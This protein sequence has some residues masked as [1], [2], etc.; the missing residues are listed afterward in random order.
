[1]NKLPQ[2][3]SC[4]A[5][6]GMVSCTAR[7]C[8]HCGHPIRT[9]RKMDAIRHFRSLLIQMTSAITHK[10]QP[11]L[12]ICLRVSFFLLVM[13]GFVCIN[14]ILRIGDLMNAS[15]VFELFLFSAL[16]PATIHFPA[17]YFSRRIINPK[18]SFYIGRFSVFLIGLSMVASSSV[19]ER[20]FL[21]Q[22]YRYNAIRNNGLSMTSAYAICLLI[23]V[24]WT[25]VLWRETTKSEVMMNIKH[26]T[27]DTQT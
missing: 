15:S 19:I 3:F 21:Y 11:I 6:H 24:C 4:P 26:K 25:V 1:M 8:P 23:M 14:G 27:T 2:L 17:T 12:Q 10:M 22:S 16:C 20:I 18:T 7:S 5:C 13:A 9:L